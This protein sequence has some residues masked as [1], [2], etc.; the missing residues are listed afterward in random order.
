MA[1]PRPLA[2]ELLATAALWA[3]VAAAFAGHTYL[4]FAAE[5]RPV[6]VAVALWWSAAEWAP[7]VPLT[8]LV[9]RLVRRNLPHAPAAAST[10]ARARRAAALAAA[11]VLVAA[12]QIAIEYGVD[13]A[14]VALSGDPAATVRTWLGDGVAAAPRHA[15]LDLPYLLRRKIGFGYVTYWAVVAVVVAVEYHRLFRDRELRAARLEGALAGAQLDALVAQLQPHFLFNALN[16]VASLIPDDPPAAEEVVESLSEL[17]RASLGEARR[18]EIPLARELELLEQYLA[19]QRARFHARLSVRREL[20][21]ALGD[22]LVPP[23]LLQPLVENALRHGIARRAAGGT[24]VVRT[25]LSGGR[26]ELA[27][28]DDGPGFAAAGAEG[29]GLA[30]TRARLA[31][32]YAGGAELAVGD[33]AGGGAYARVRLPLR[34]AALAS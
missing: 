29:V 12:A 21:P 3:L 30:N 17:L 6:S 27:V 24:V 33:R 5:G 7:W 4:T 11:G 34:R 1:P 10:A 28:E 15:P 2:A 31:R 13:R 8:P 25:A 14:A 20:D 26:V 9:V 22:A 19:I 32:L 18:R 16:T 23:M